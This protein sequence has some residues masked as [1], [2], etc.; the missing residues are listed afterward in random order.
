MSTLLVLSHS[1]VLRCGIAVTPITNWRLYGKLIQDFTITLSL[2]IVMTY[3]Y[4]VKRKIYVMK[5]LKG[6]IS[7]GV[8]PVLRNPLALIGRVQNDQNAH[9]AF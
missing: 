9:N 7:A 3:E 6:N 4:P 5:A 8:L 1:S 2:V